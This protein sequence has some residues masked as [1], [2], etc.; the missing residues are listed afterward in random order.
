M[1]T[2][3]TPS[4]LLGGQTLYPH[5]R[6]QFQSTFG[7][8]QLALALNLEPGGPENTMLSRSEH[9]LDR[10]NLFH[11]S[12]RILACAERARNATAWCFPVRLALP[13]H[14]L[15]PCLEPGGPEN[16][17]LSRSE[18]A[19][20]RER[21]SHINCM[22]RA[23]SERDSMVFS[24]SPGSPEPLARAMPRAR[25]PGKHNVVAFRTRLGS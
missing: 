4:S 25:R 16:T 10:E 19:L 7:K 11:S 1:R 14:W 9:A 21:L 23:R 24:G 12:P 15:E 5:Y 22:R 6:H 2:P 17:M 20:D 3:C 18:H 13:S 8:P